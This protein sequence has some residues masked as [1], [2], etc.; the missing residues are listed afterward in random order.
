M[1]VNDLV[2]SDA[3]VDSLNS[4]PSIQGRGHFRNVFV[5]PSEIFVF[6]VILLPH[7]LTKENFCVNLLRNSFFECLVDFKLLK[8]NYRNFCSFDLE[9]F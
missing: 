6:L 2:N 1:L 3:T 8:K 4:M 7:R 5:K 9:K